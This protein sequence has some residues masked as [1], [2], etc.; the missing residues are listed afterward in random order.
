MSLKRR[1]TALEKRQVE[2]IALA[3]QRA[4]CAGAQSDRFWEQLDAKLQTAGHWCVPGEDFFSYLARGM[5][6]DVGTLRRAVANQDQTVLRKFTS[7]VFERFPDLEGAWRTAC[8][9]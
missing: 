6:F 1:V 2:L 4:E 5:G 7:A 3:K 9:L 8:P